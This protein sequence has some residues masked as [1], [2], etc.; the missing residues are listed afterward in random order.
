[1]FENYKN[2]KHTPSHHQIDSDALLLIEIY[3]WHISSNW[4]MYRINVD[5][6][7]NCIWV[8][9]N[10]V[11]NA[12]EN[13]IKIQFSIRY[14]S[15]HQLKHFKY[16]LLH[17]CQCG[18]VALAFGFIHY[19]RLT[20]YTFN[21][22][23]RIRTT[24][25]YNSRMKCTINMVGSHWLACSPENTHESTKSHAFRL[26]VRMNSWLAGKFACKTLLQQRK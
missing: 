12:N 8:L 5:I 14:R 2:K 16:F 7:L 9:L 3:T 24:Q 1:M 18:L 6:Q 25:S 23:R 20:F 15:K 26:C 13:Q 22:V 17:F 21:G 4:K 19:L 10:Y 11:P